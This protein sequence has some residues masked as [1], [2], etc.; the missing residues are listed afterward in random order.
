MLPVVAGAATMVAVFSRYMRSATLEN[1]TE[2]YVR[3]APAGGSS[4]GP[5]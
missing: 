1:L 5:S 3:T 4:P 2:D